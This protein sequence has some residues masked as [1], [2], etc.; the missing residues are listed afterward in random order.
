MVDAE[1]LAALHDRE[2]TADAIESIAA[3]IEQ[4][5]QATESITRNIEEAARY[6]NSIAEHVSSVSA[7]T[8]RT[9]NDAVEMW[10]VS[11][12]LAKQA[13]T[14]RQEVDLFLVGMR[15]EVA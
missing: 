1:A 8:E 10:K 2:L 4:Q 14:L 6:A 13:E 15:S 5:G 12:D 3:A 7:M 9:G 11:T